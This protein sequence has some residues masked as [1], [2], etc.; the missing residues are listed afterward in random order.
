MAETNSRGPDSAVS[1]VSHKSSQTPSPPFST[2][3]AHNLA[4]LRLLGLEAVHEPW[5]R[6]LLRQLRRE[7]PLPPLEVTSKPVAVKQ[8]WGAY[9]QHGRG[10]LCSTALHLTA[11]VLLFT[12]LS[13]PHLE[14]VA[15]HS[16]DLHIPVDAAQFLAALRKEMRGGGG[17]GTNS[18]L[19]VSRGRLP[20]FDVTQLAPAMIEP[21]ENARLMVEPTL[22]GPRDI[23]VATLDLE[24]FGD[25][26]AGVGPPSQGPGGGGGFGDNNGTGI[27]PGDGAGYGPG[28][29]GAGGV[30]RIGGSVSAPVLVRRV[31]PEY[32]DAARKA[33]LQ[34]TVV[35]LIE[36]GP[37]GRAHNIRVENGLGL[38]LDEEAVKA[39]EQW[40]FKPGLKDGLPVRVGAR[41]EVHFRL[42]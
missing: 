42:L 3:G 15:L 2:Q 34:G 11:V 25:P 41:V 20:R 21:V 28:K 26:L 4:E 1:R 30:W 8:I 33:R 35:L 38:G 37:D 17:G 7:P 27:G 40:R 31:D 19:P 5:Y 22:L 24:W 13:S 14:R 32:S 23:Q 12:V 29:G 39:V 10:L 6:S 9:D 18:P 36:V 16:I